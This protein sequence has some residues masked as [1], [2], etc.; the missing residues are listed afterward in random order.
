MLNLRSLAYK[1]FARPIDPIGKLTKWISYHNVKEVSFYWLEDGTFLSTWNFQVE[2][3]LDFI[4]SRILSLF[5]THEFQKT[6]ENLSLLDHT[7]I[8]QGRSFF[9]EYVR[10][11]ELFVAETLLLSLVTIP[12]QTFKC[13]SIFYPQQN[14][15][16]AR[17]FARRRFWELIHVDK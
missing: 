15:A 4:T 6:F 14:G 7:S 3:V 16:G 13:A 9:Q 1:A 10:W 17:E 12:L 8:T 2:K 11:G 5:P